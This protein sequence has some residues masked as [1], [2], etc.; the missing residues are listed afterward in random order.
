[1]AQSYRRLRVK[2]FAWQSNTNTWRVGGHEN[3]VIISSCTSHFLSANCYFLS[4]FSCRGV[5]AS[6]SR[7]KKQKQ[8]LLLGAHNPPLIQ[9]YSSGSVS[10][11]R[12]AVST[13]TEQQH[14]VPMS[15]RKEQSRAIP[16]PPPPTSQSSRARNS[17]EGFNTEIEKLVWRSNEATSNNKVSC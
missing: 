12:V 5:E 17:V 3:E 1:M 4:R 13:N 10:P 7:D 2:S 6:P 15:D 11:N 9:Q 14:H 16:V 8:R